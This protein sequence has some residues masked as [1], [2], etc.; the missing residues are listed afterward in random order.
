MLVSLM[1][2]SNA[3]PTQIFCISNSLGTQATNAHN[4]TANGSVL[5]TSVKLEFSEGYENIKLNNVLQEASVFL[6]GP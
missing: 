1:I 4:W 5:A 2:L 3:P 6:M